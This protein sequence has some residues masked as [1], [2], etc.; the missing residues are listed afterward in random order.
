MRDG[1]Q[2]PFGRKGYSG[3]RVLPGKEC[4]AASGRSLIFHGVTVGKPSIDPAAI[5]TFMARSVPIIRGAFRDGLDAEPGHH[6][7]RPAR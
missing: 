4:S 3:S 2:L 7:R 5:A 1:I 6:I